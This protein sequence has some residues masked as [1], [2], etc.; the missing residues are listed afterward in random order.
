MIGEV[1]A[2][3]ECSG[4]NEGRSPHVR[5]HVSLHRWTGEDPGSFAGVSPGQSHPLK[6]GPAPRFSP[7]PLA[8]RSSHVRGLRGSFVRNMSRV[9]VCNWTPLHQCR[10]IWSSLV[11]RDGEDRDIGRLPFC[12]SRRQYC[13]NV[14]EGFFVLSKSHPSSRERGDQTVKHHT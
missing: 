5:P 1:P 13:A 9:L 14:D 4:A 2:A 11:H 3:R 12:S 10:A 7:P 6:G 8:V